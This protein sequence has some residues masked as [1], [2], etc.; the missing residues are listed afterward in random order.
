V[1]KHDPVKFNRE[2]NEKH[3]ESGLTLWVK[4]DQV[5]GTYAILEEVTDRGLPSEVTIRWATIKTEDTDGSSEAKW[6]IGERL[7]DMHK[8][9]LLRAIELGVDPT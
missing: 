2:W 7:L 3:R 8:N 9:R 6:K 1:V 5:L 4:V